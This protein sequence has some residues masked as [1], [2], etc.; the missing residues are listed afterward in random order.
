MMGFDVGRNPYNCLS[1]AAKA[2]AVYSSPRQNLNPIFSCLDARKICRPDLEVSKP[3]ITEMR[4]GW[5]K[6]PAQLQFVGR[7][8][9]LVRRIARA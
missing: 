6:A 3:L 9:P 8:Y 2:L 5:I 7:V 1:W 4:G